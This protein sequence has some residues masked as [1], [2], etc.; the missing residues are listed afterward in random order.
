M[1]AQ[2]EGKGIDP[3]GSGLPVHQHGL[4]IVPQ[5]PQ[6]GSFDEPTRQLP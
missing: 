3:L 2:A 1:K 6:S 5:A 4:G